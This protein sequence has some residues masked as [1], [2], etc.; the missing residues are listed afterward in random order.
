MINKKT[1]SYSATYKG[2]KIEVEED[3]SG[4]ESP[5]GKYSCSISVAENEGVASDEN[6]NDKKIPADVVKKALGVEDIF[7]KERE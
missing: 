1:N 5:C 2:W 3:W 6:W 4:V 7:W